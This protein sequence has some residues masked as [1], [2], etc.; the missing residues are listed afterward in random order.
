MTQQ[1]IRNLEPKNVEAQ[2][3]YTCPVCKTEHWL[4]HKQTKI[5]E[6]KILCEGC[7]NVLIPKT[8]QSITINFK[9]EQEEIISEFDKTELEPLKARQP[10]LVKFN[11]LKEAKNTLVAF[12]FS[13]HEA[14]EMINLEYERT[15]EENPAKLVKGAIDLMGVNNG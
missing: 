12:G 3:Q 13:K 2:L 5:D 9:P 15:K 10:S 6:F 7:D 11:F 8:V 1:I 14:E 4:S